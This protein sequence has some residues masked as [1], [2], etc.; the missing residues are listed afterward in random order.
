MNNDQYPKRHPNHTLEQR[1]E[2]FFRQCV[3][4]DWSINNLNHDYGQDLNI[5]IAEDGKYRGLELIVQL[6]S[7][8]NSAVVADSETQPISVST[9]NYLR[10]NLRVVLFVKYIASENEAYWILLKDV[11]PPNQEQKTFTLH[12]PRENKLSSLNWKIIA[13]YVRM[14]TDRKLAAMRVEQRERIG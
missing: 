5:E 12:I 4:N 6:K 7:S 2:T 8:E 9:F 14:V 1:S 3:P 10:D 11:A 13:E